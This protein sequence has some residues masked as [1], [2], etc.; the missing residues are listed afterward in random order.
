MFGKCLYDLERFDRA[1]RAAQKATAIAPDDAAAWRTEALALIMAHRD[2][3]QTLDRAFAL[4]PRDADFDLAVGRAFMREGRHGE[5]AGC[6]RRA[7]AAG[8]E[9][10]RGPL[11]QS[12]MA[13]GKPVDA[14]KVKLGD[15]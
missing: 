2:P 9:S 4:S 15:R 12:L 8:D 6:F 14:L 11:E 13:A 10:A 5:A 7:I 1:A 3:G